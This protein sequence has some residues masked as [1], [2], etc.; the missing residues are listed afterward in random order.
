[1]RH[2]LLVLRKV[3]AWSELTAQWL[4]SESTNNISELLGMLVKNRLLS[5]ER[6]MEWLQ[7]RTR[8]RCCSI[9]RVMLAFIR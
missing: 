7:V 5:Y 4:L 1:M 9:E 8:A 6:S 2:L 3:L